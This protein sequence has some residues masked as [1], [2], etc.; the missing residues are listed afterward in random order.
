[1]EEIVK[2]APCLCKEDWQ[3]EAKTTMKLDFFKKIQYHLLRLQKK[4]VLLIR[5]CM[6][7]ALSVQKNVIRLAVHLL[8]LFLRIICCH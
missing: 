6:R 1:M 3:D 8:E 4:A 5:S 7:M 2:D